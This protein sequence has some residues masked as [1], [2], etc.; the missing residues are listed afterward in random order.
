M[1]IYNK[2]IKILSLI[3]VAVAVFFVSF[4][5][6]LEIQKEQFLLPCQSLPLGD[7]DGYLQSRQ[8][9][10]VGEGETL[11]KQN[12]LPKITDKPTQMLF[13]G[14]M[15]L[16]RHVGEKIDK[17]GLEYIFEK[18]AA[19]AN[20]DANFEGEI[21]ESRLQNL[22][23]NDNNFFEN[24]DLIGCNL[25]GTITNNGAHY[26]PVMLYDFAF[27][28][29]L[30]LQLKDYGFNFFN[31]ANNHLAD[32]GGRGIIETRENLDRLGFNYT[33]CRDGKVGECSS[34]VV[35]A[36]DKKIGIAGF[37]MVYSKLNMVEAEKVINNL[38][39]TTDLVIVNM[40]WGAEYE[41]QFNK[42][43]QETAH[44]LIDA[45]ADII[46]GHHPHVVQ[47]IELYKSR[48]ATTNGD[49]PNKKKGVIFYSLGNFVFDQYFSQDTQEGLAIGISASDQAIEFFLYPLKSKLSQVELMVGEEKE[50]FL[51][52]LIEWSKVDEEIGGQIQSGKLIFK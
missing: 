41:H 20:P 52:E 33:G 10:P 36:A 4:V 31:L 46:I 6:Y 11:P 12:T 30:I 34:T 47:G 32:Q 42:L 3:A 19:S 8:S 35:E 14:D 7:S 29:E 49:H 43:Q 38:A 15:M 25:E 27:A 28:P 26:N 22:A 17:Y 1:Q 39:S 40:H 23:R 37:S 21:R 45:G 48:L 50:K 51:Q 16:D 44:T 2:I 9:P 24:Y 18:L 5:F 13:F